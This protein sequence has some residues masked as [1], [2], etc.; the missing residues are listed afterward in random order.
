MSNLQA[1]CGLAQIQRIEALIEK[2]RLIFSWYKKYLGDCEWV[3]LNQE[4]ENTRNIYWM[5]TVSIK[6]GVKISRDDLIKKLKENNID[7][8]PV[9]Y[10]ISSFPMFETESANVNSFSFSK[11]GINLPSGHNLEE[12][13]VSYICSIIKKELKY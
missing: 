7:S 10:P 6:D 2:K 4:R 13:D 11:S 3:I 12:E 5:S 8:R 9:F 1:A